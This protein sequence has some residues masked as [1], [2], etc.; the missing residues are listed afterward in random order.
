M[1]DLADSEE[2][3]RRNA[4]LTLALCAI[5]LLPLGSGASAA[6]PPS[7]FGVT[8]WQ[9]QTGQLQIGAAIPLSTWSS[10]FRVGQGELVALVGKSEAGLALGHRFSAVKLEMGKVSIGA[11]LGIGGVV[12]YAQACQNMPG[13]TCSTGLRATRPVLFV[14]LPLEPK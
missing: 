9:G 2:S 12:P 14:T 3:D 1:S 7:V 6:P 4:W 13:H 5:A 8:A 11:A 10:I